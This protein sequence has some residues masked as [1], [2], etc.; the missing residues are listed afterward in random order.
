MTR[1]LVAAVA[2]VVAACTLAAGPAKAQS[3]FFGE[4]ITVAGKYC[5]EGFAV[6]AGNV[7][8]VGLNQPL[9]AAIGS[10]FGGNGINTFGLPNLVGRTPVGTGQGPDLPDVV[11]GQTSGDTTTVNVETATAKSVDVP[12]TQSPSVTL[13]HCIA[14]DGDFPGRP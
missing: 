7:L 14:L 3:P 1:A 9:F 13:L 4:V 5:P 11:I 8:V 12:A 6:A 10:V 2:T